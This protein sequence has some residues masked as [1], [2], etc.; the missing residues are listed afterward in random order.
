MITGL[1][2]MLASSLWRRSF[3]TNAQLPLLLP[4]QKVAALAGAGVA[5]MYVLL[6]GF[7]VP[8]IRIRNATLDASN[9]R[10]RLM[11]KRVHLVC[12]R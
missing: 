5:L 6:A 11:A 7:G 8:A 4:A 2:A 3:F 9:Y 12:R 1:F 10:R